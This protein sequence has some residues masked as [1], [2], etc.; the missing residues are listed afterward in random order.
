MTLIATLF[1]IGAIFLG[2]EI[3][4]PGGILGVFAGVALVGGIVLAF[5]DYSVMGGGVAIAVALVLVGLVLYIEIAILPKTAMGKRFFLQSAISG[6]SSAAP[7]IDLNGKSGVTSTVLAPS[8]YIAIDGQRYE[9][10]SRRGLLEK[11]V[12]VKVVGADNF[13]LIV[14][15]EN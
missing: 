10:Y 1:I 2:L 8:G 15:P 12:A 14:T 9:A 4:L 6:T 13:R 5:M 11:G 3:F 7:A